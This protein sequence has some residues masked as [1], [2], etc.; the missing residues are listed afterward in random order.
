MKKDLL[1]HFLFTVAFFLLATL[2]KNWFNSSYYLFWLGGLVG[3][4]LPDADYFIYIYFLNPE[5]QISQQ[6]TALIE[7]RSV[8][9]SWD[10]LATARSQHS[11]LIFHSVYFQLIF[12]VFSFLVVT[13]SSLFGRGMVLAFALHLLV[14]QATD[15][16][17]RGGIKHWFAKLNIA[18][19]PRQERW[20]LLAQVF[21][22][23]TLGFV[24]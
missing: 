7:K 14:D 19:N 5:K 4:I 10:L 15:Q 9:K 3:M 24:F 13:S 16:V 21:V 1:T 2:V 20:Y 12:L 6:A 17:E 11:D 8:L 23:V 18:L 22:L